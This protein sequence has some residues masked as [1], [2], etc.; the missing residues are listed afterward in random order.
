M[1]RN[2]LPLVCWELEKSVSIRTYTSAKL[3]SPGKDPAVCGV[4]DHCIV[5]RTMKR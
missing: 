3:L 1:Y 4:G 2:L 5:K